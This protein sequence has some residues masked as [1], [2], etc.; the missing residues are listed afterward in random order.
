MNQR[1]NQ[2]NWEKKK[3][4]FTNEFRKKKYDIIQACL[5]REDPK[6]CLKNKE[7]LSRATAVLERI[8]T[9]AF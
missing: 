2:Q 1:N 3:K 8:W 7:T 5:E 6:N 4:V 9:T